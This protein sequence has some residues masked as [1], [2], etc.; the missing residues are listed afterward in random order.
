[1]ESI[2]N[3]GGIVIDLPAILLIAKK[4]G[5]PLI[6][7]NTLA[8]TLPLPAE[9][10]RRRYHRAFADQ[11]HGRTR[12]RAIGGVLV[13][14]GTFDWMKAK[15]RYKTLVEPN[16]SYGG[17]VLSEAFGNM[18]FA[19]AARVMGLRDIGL[20]IAPM[21]A[22][23][24]LTGIETLALRWSRHCEN[25]LTV[26]R[27]LEKHPKGEV[28][29]LC[30]ASR[31]SPNHALA[32]RISPNG[33]GAVFTSELKGGYDAGVKLVSTLK[34]FSHLA[35]IG[36]VRSLVIHP[37][38]TPCSCCRGAGRCM[39]RRGCSRA[40]DFTLRQTLLE[41]GDD[42]GDVLDAD[43]EAHHIRP[44]AG[45]KALCVGELA[46][47]R[48]GRVNDEASDVA[49]VG[50]MREQFQRRDEL[51][52]GI[53]SALQAEREHSAG[54]T[55]TKFGQGM[56]GAGGE[57]GVVHPGTVGMLFQPRRHSKR[58]VAMP[59][60]PERQRLDAGQNEKGIHRRDRRSDVAQAHDARGNRKG[61]VAEGLA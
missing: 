8:D 25:T 23:L 7:D 29:E 18:A 35:N 14:C 46:V 19:I 58:V 51:H 59:G 26:A 47:G 17:M 2:A 31:Q 44:G 61:H 40:F 4:A 6:V 55:R 34:L 20:A 28:G 43:R 11:V 38:S 15:H 56:I 22:F 30:W 50:E 54:A 16:A 1:M 57:P 13:D 60:H 41:V 36:D 42:I 21:N 5:V 48:G 12:Q 9:G 10:T 39:W 3:P 53:V 52:A 27:W 33:T 24:I 49:D 45:G 37:A 32:K